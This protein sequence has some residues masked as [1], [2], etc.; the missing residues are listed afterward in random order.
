M[1]GFVGLA[2]ES[3]SLSASQVRWGGETEKLQRLPPGAIPLPLGA[4]R[5]PDVE[6][7]ALLDS[8]EELRER[9]RRLFTR[10]RRQV[11]RKHAKVVGRSVGTDP[12]PK[13]AATACLTLADLAAAVGGS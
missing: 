2:V 12:P 13:G 10:A 6:R 7:A 9:A 1:S 8:G 5:T 4:L 3:T 11:D